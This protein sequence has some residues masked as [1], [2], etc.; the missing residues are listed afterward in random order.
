MARARITAALACAGLG[1]AGSTTAQSLLYAL[2]GQ[3]KN[4]LFGMSVAAAG[5]VNGDGLA[6][7][8]I[9]ADQSPHGLGSP[10]TGAGY[11][12][13]VSGTTG[14]L[15][16]AFHGDAGDDWFGTAVC[17][18]G[19][20]NGD[21][22]DDIAVLA[23]QPGSASYPPYVQGT[24]PGP[25]YLRI[26]SGANGA[27]L[28]NLVG[29]GT[30]GLFGHSMA[31]AGD[32]NAD[33][34]PDIIVGEIGGLVWGYDPG[35]ARIYSGLD[36]S[37]LHQLSVGDDG[38]WFGNSVD[39][40]GDVDGDGYDDVVVGAP[41]FGPPVGLAAVYSGQS[42]LLIRAWLGNSI[43]DEFGFAVAGAGDVNGD[44]VPDLVIA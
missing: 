4:D 3:G 23:P 12:R 14:A 2:P 42:G 6:D 39:G 30:P 22:Y 44:G 5:D 27:V 41:Y 26:L 17:G 34:F 38:D 18:P 37:L 13:V 28:T 31:A 43:A 16:Y 24:P 7:V 9:G 8:V 32:V 19:D 11:A 21:G 10:P 33:G 36:G 29:S 20:V 25:G 35:I 40:A 15:L 1:L